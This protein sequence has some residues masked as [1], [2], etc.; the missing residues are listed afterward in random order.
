MTHLHITSKKETKDKLDRHF[1]RL[2]YTVFKKWAGHRPESLGARYM[3]DE[4]PDQLLSHITPILD[5]NQIIILGQ[6]R[7]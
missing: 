7:I 4:L 5:E 3:S 1:K 6:N 2:N